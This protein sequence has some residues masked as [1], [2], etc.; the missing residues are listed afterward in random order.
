[1]IGIEVQL[2]RREKELPYSSIIVPVVSISFSLL[3]AGLVLLLLG[4]SPIELY[5]SIYRALISLGTA[6]YMIPLLLCGV[7]L[8]IAFRANVWNIGAEGQIL[9]GAI[10]S[11]GMALYM[12]PENLNPF[13]S[14]I[15]LYACS[16]LFG[17]FWAFIP[18]VLKAKLGVNE[19]LSTLMLN[20][21]AAQLVNYLVYGPWKGLREYGYPRSDIIPR[22]FW[23]PTIPKTGIHISTLALGLAIAVLAYILLYRTKLGFEIRVVGENINAARY[24]GISISKVIIIAMI[25]SGGLAG[26]AG[27]GEIIGVHHQLIRAERLSAGYGYTAIIVAW[28]AKLNP[29]IA[30]PSAFLIAG[31][32]SASYTLQIS[33]G[34][35]YGAVNVLTGLILASLITLDFMSKYSLKLRIRWKT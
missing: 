29:I 14:L 23:A 27:A 1:L 22:T 18:A 20:Y 12:L 10:V 5:Y 33:L 28:L 24:A 21:I 30:I 17:A 7:G 11:T 4:K 15:I 2:K 26:I 3:V 35:G 6:K 32:V 8:S 19:V 25:I 9:L 13:I 31:L 34:I 16:F